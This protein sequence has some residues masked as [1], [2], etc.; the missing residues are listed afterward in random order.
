MAS[1]LRLR[2]TDLNLYTILRVKEPR[3]RWEHRPGGKLNGVDMPSRYKKHV[4]AW[5]YIINSYLASITSWLFLKTPWTLL[6]LLREKPSKPSALFFQPFP[7]PSRGEAGSTAERLMMGD[8]F[9]LFNSVFFFWFSTMVNLL[10][11][12]IPHFII[13]WKA[14]PCQTLC[15]ESIGFFVRHNPRFKF[16]R[17]RFGVRRVLPSPSQCQKTAFFSA[18][19][20]W[21]FLREKWLHSK[22]PA[23]MFS[24]VNYIRQ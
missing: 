6:I 3:V 9:C 13:P 5:I 11:R 12:E 15:E 8:S 7:R 1:R 22:N 14:R 23:P 16:A 24:V 2:S 18:L 4:C 20:P 19:N 21:R 10:V 17:F